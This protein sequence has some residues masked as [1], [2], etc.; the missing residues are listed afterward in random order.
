MPRLNKKLSFAV[1]FAN[2]SSE[3]GIPAP[4]LAQMIAAAKKS[5][6]CY[7]RNDSAGEQRWGGVVEEIAERHG[8]EVDWPGL[9]P[10]IQKKGD[11]RSNRLLPS[12][13]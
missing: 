4:D 13:D 5:A 11:P 7:E 12:H 9:W 6:N 8:C 2:Y 3:L 10:C 1:Q